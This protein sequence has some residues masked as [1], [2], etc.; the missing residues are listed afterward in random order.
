MVQIEFDADAKLSCLANSESWPRSQTHV[1]RG[2]VSI[3]KKYTTEKELTI[4]SAPLLLFSLK[5]RKEKS[6]IQIMVC[7][8]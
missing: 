2:I 6:M 3:I 1:S 5:E 7:Q 8:P 4:K